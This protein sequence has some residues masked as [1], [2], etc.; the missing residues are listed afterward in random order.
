MYQLSERAGGIEAR[1]GEA[2][3]PPPLTCVELL[4]VVLG[5]ND[6]GVLGEDIRPHF[7]PVFGSLQAAKKGDSNKK[8][9]EGKG[10][11]PCRRKVKE[12]VRG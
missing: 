2:P 1:R 9:G 5:D 7:F 11:V 12:E 8:R 6:V 3:F 10:R 4:E